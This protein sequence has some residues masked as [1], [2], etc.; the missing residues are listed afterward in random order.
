MRAGRT[1]VLAVLA[2]A[3]LA[4]S[5]SAPAAPKPL[6]RAAFDTRV[7]A[8]GR[9]YQHDVSTLSVKSSGSSSAAK[10][11]AMASEFE[12]VY[13]HLAARLGLLIP[14]KEIAADYKVMVASFRDEVGY[15]AAWRDA[16]LHGTAQEAAK[17]SMRLDFNPA[18]TR[19]QAAA[20]RITAKGYDLGVFSA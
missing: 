4:V 14:P 2:A 6:S 9:Q 19:A 11:A 15:A 12:R 10:E 7:Q 18:I 8:I 3:V 1:L 13:R 17:A 5:A 20:A 16:A